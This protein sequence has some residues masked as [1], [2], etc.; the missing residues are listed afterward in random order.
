MEDIKEYGDLNESELYEFLHIIESGDDDLAEAEKTSEQIIEAEEECLPDEMLDDAWAYK[1][2]WVKT[3]DGRF[4]AEFDLIL[5]SEEDEYKQELKKLAEEEKAKLKEMA[6]QRSVER[7]KRRAQ[8]KIDIHRAAFN[9]S[10]I[11]LS[12]EVPR[13]LL[14]KL[15]QSLTSI[16]TEMIDKLYTYINN[17]LG[18]LLMPLIPRIVKHC[19]KQFPHSVLKCQGFMYVASKEYGRERY[20]WATPNIPY[21]FKQGTEQDI[22]K[23]YKS[24]FLYNIDKAISQYDYHRDMLNQKEIRYAAALIN[25]GVRTY[26]DLLKY[27]PFWFEKLYRIVTQE[28]LC[29]TNC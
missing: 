7:E 10:N 20:F 21:F 17:R 24:T 22:L 11:L 19:A 28:E 6:I 12:D 9:Q 27:N 16:H 29:I 25:K 23:K 15:I 5:K 26:F 1:R 18:T 2:R 13:E 14:T 4:K 8:R 3:E